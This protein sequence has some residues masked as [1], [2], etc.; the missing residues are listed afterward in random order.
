MCFDETGLIFAFKA[1]NVQRVNVRQ[2]N[3]QIS[4]QSRTSNDLKGVWGLKLQFGGYFYI[5][6]RHTLAYQQRMLRHSIHSLSATW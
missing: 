3:K 5:Q 1:H 6:E 4:R 2:A